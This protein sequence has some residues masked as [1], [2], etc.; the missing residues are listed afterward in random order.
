MKS[1]RSRKPAEAAGSFDLGALL[2]QRKASGL[3]AGRCSAA[4]AG[5]IRQIREE[6]LYLAKGVR[7]GEF[8]Q[9]HL[10][11]SRTQADRLIRYLD[12]FGPDY[13]EVAQLTRIP[14]EAYR[15]IAHAVKDGHIY[16][17]NEAIALLPENTEKVAAAVA[18]L[19]EA[20]K[21]PEEEA[22][23]APPAM[24]ALK[25]RGAEVVAGWARLVASRAMLPP[26]E[27]QQLKN[28][29]GRMRQELQRLENQVWG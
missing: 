3:I 20:A 15:A 22:T 19:R 6:K 24:E 29:I 28:L 27:R 4:E 5:T 26:S 13:F 1:L 14:P 16:W 18:G 9:N 25:E 12:E 2:G 11:M 21:T 23:P 17:Q 7:W 8:C 10:G